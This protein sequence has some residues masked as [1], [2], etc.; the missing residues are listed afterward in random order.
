MT[1]A[2]FRAALAA[3]ISAVRAQAS[4]EEMARIVA[5]LRK[6]SS[7]GLFFADAIEHGAHNASR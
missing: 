2:D 7:T 4:A 5:W 6:Q 3:A 1:P